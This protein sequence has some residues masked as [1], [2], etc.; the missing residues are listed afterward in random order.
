[1]LTTVV[2][3]Q[4]YYRPTLKQSRVQACKVLSMKGLIL[5]YQIEDGI[6]K[7]LKFKYSVE[8]FKNEFYTN[9]QDALAS[10]STAA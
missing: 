1:M 8:R 5:D 6:N 3:N 2:V 10:I 9:K 7:G 4:I